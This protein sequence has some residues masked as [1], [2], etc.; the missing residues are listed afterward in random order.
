MG[1]VIEVFWAM[2]IVGVPIGAFTLAMVWWSLQRGHLKESLDIK[3]LQ[4]E[5]KSLSKSKKK[6]NKEGNADAVQHPLQKKWMKFG[7]GFY[8]IVA[9]FTYIVVEVIE[10]STMIINFG[11]FFDFLRQL[12]FDVIINIL[13]NAVTNFITA[14]IWPLY[15]LKRI[16]TDQTWIWFVVAYGGYWL[17]LKLAQAL[18][19]RRF[20]A[21]T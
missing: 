20:G 13:I 17:G 9:F 14:M 18:V 4:R 6:K 3:A 5:M 12:S 19:Q 10:I 15:W 16:D 1:F 2:L 11:G 8:G 21:E 7:G